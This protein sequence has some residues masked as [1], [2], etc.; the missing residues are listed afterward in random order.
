MRYVR[1]TKTRGG[2]FFSP[3]VFFFCRRN[4]FFGARGLRHPAVA[5]ALCRRSPP[6]SRNFWRGRRDESNCPTIDSRRSAA[7]DGASPLSPPAGCHKLGPR[8]RT[9]RSS[10]RN[11]FAHHGI[12]T[13]RGVYS[14][15]PYCETLRPSPVARSMRHELTMLTTSDEACLVH[16]PPEP[17]GPAGGARGRCPLL[18]HAPRCVQGPRLAAREEHESAPARSSGMSPVRECAN[19]L[20]VLVGSGFSRATQREADHALTRSCFVR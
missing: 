7:S 8:D 11:T 20:S 15:P 5:C 14:H 2:F 10:A 18:P 12:R 4:Y 9:P 1:S 13:G 17:P 16:K 3:S 6:K 19:R